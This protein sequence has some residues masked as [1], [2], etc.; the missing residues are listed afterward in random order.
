MKVREYYTVVPW[1]RLSYF[2]TYQ[3][4]YIKCQSLFRYQYSLTFRKKYCTTNFWLVLKLLKIIW[5]DEVLKIKTENFFD[6]VHTFYYL[7]LFYFCSL[8]KSQHFTK[9]V[10]RYCSKTTIVWILKEGNAGRQQRTLLGL[11]LK[12]QTYIIYI[13]GN[14]FWYFSPVSNKVLNTYQ[15]TTCIG[16]YIFCL[17]HCAF[18]IVPW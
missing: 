15:N 11:P 14:T 7:T 18:C 9:C 6:Y 4:N 2:T 10:P 16:K 8:V 3:N 12:L 1:L 13:L 17:I 5:F